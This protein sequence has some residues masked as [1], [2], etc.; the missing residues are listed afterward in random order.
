MGWWEPKATTIWLAAWAQNAGTFPLCMLI[1]ALYALK[2]ITWFPPFIVVT[3]CCGFLPL[4]LGIPLAVFGHAAIG[5]GISWYVGAA[6]TGNTW[7]PLF[8][9]FHPDS[10]WR[11]ALCYWAFLPTDV[12]LTGLKNAKV[13]PFH[14]LTGCLPFVIIMDVTIVAA[15]KSIIALLLEFLGR[16]V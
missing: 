10:W 6:S 8:K 16:A 11:V 4:W 3:I 14:A 1:L 5:H 9:N 15:G 12:V 13:K 7:K 2:G